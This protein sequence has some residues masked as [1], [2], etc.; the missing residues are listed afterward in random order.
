MSRRLVARDEQRHVERHQLPGRKRPALDLRTDEQRDDVVARVRDLVTRVLLEERHELHDVRQCFSAERGT[1]VRRDDRRVRPAA[2]VGA[3]RVGDA[4]E[5]A[6][7]E[8]RQRR[9]EDVHEIDDLAGRHGIEQRPDERPDLPLHPA[10][11]PPRELPVQDA[12]PARVLGR[13]HVQDRAVDRPAFAQRVVDQGAPPGAE[14][15][16][17]PADRADVVIPGDRLRRRRV[18]E[19]RCVDPQPRQHLVVVGL[20]EEARRPRIDVQVADRGHRALAA[21]MR[22]ARRSSSGLSASGSIGD[23]PLRSSRCASRVMIAVL[24]TIASTS[25]HSRSCNDRPARAS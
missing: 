9:G 2:E 11:R 15:L 19:H 7:H 20:Q 1:P 21:A 10:H 23:R 12:P 18:L 5:I 25:N 17:I 16:R 24:L 13:V 4:E 8:H 22:R 3:V 14:R 6:D